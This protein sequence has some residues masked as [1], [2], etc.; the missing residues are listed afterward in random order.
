MVN[1]AVVLGNQQYD[2]QSITIIPRQGTQAIY[3][4]QKGKKVKHIH[5]LVL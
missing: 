4:T 3:C 5:K 2:P 1:G